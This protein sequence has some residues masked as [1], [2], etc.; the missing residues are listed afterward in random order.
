MIHVDP[1]YSGV[2]D[3]KAGATLILPTTFTCTPPARVTW[4][5]N[6]LPLQP[7]PGHVHID[8]RDNCSTL[9]V[10]GV[11]RDEAGAYELVVEN[12]AGTASAAFDVV[13]KCEI[14]AR[15]PCYAR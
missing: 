15:R 14:L 5:H 13:V 2:R 12:A 8:T 3:V 1:Y 4:L 10:L 11:E 6:G 9:T 7:R